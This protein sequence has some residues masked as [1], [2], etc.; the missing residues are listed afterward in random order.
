MR[1]HFTLIELLVVIGIIA[2]LMGLLLPAL[3]HARE[4]ARRTQCK[5][6]LKQVGT[7]TLMYA[8]D[9]SALPPNARSG[10]TSLSTAALRDGGGAIG[11]GLVAVQQAEARVFGCP[12]HQPRTP[13]RV[14]A[15]WA[16][17]GATMGAYLYREQDNP[18]PVQLGSSG[19]SVKTGIFMD[20][21]QAGSEEA[22]RGKWTQIFFRDGAVIGKRNTPTVGEFFTHDGSASVLD[23]VW[24]NA[25]DR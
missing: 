6:N 8:M 12:S 15:D 25:D 19:P 10:Y 24:D 22:H 1:R 20:N 5:S 3:A 17:G 2:I 11:V 18:V 9:Y 13:D 23:T 4:R 14:A 21:N 7:S 16:A